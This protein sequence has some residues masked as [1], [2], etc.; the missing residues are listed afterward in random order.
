[1]SLRLFAAIPITENLK[2][3]FLEFSQE[4]KHKNVRWVDPDNFHITIQFFGNIAE[5]N[6][7]IFSTKLAGLSEKINPFILNFEQIIQ[8][9]PQAIPTML[10]AVFN[11]N[12]EYEKLVYGVSKIAEPY[13]NKKFWNENT[14]RKKRIPHVTLARSKNRKPMKKLHISQPHISK[15]ELK[16]NSFELWSSELKPSGAK[17]TTLNTFTFNFGD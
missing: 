1:M 15:R 12:G 6:L 13:I 16:V 11:G 7:E 4:S 9:P 8:A 2:H 17:Y 5:K 14:M 3:S 10:W